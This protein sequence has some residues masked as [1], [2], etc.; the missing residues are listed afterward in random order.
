MGEE[1]DMGFDGFDDQTLTFTSFTR[2]RRQTNVKHI[3]LCYIILFITF[4][5]G[6]YQQKSYNISRLSNS[7]YNTICEISGV[8]VEVRTILL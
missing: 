8:T 3:I 6:F 1:D 7:I 4:L 5:G 2:N